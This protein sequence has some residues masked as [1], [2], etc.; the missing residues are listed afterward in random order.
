MNI[1]IR[2]AIP[3]IAAPA[4]NPGGP[5]NCP[6]AKPPAIAPVAVAPAIRHPEGLE[7]SVTLTLAI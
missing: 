6:P 3:P 5:K 4:A 2:V 7:Y 1:L